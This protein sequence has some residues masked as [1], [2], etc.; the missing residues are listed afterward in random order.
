MLR[1]EWFW[2]VVVALV[3][4]IA[5]FSFLN[6]LDSQVDLAAPLG[7]GEKKASPIYVITGTFLWIVLV[8]LIVAYYANA[9]AASIEINTRDVADEA[10]DH[11][12]SGPGIIVATELEDPD[13]FSLATAYYEALGYHRVDQFEGTEGQAVELFELGAPKSDRSSWRHKGAIVYQNGQSASFFVNILH[14]DGSWK[15]GSEQYIKRLHYMRPVKIVTAIDREIIKFMVDKSDYLLAIGLASNSDAS[16]T[17]QGNTKLAIARGYNL[18]YAA[19]ELDW[20][21]PNRL[22]AYWL[23]GAKNPPEDEKLE[24]LQRSAILVGVSAPQDVIVGDVL[25]AAM[26]IIDV[27]GV[28]LNGYRHPPSKPKRVKR[29]I[30]PGLG[31]FKVDDVELRTSTDGESDREVLPAIDEDAD[32]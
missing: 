23:G 19:L 22:R 17:S 20:K 29:K 1:M 25:T 3:A 27:P 7:F 16:S 9:K 26:Q 30:E 10:A 8:A 4:P 31:Y 2:I 24:P 15:F 11:S 13:P 21:E 12:S 14:S 6:F 28:D 18:A 32:R 5:A